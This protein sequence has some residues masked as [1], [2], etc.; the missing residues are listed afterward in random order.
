MRLKELSKTCDACPAQWEGRTVDNQFVYVRFRW[1]WLQIGFGK[2]IEDAINSS[3]AIW[4]SDDAYDGVMNTKDML[5]LA[6]LEIDA[7]LDSI[8][9]LLDIP[10]EC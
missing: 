3:K 10:Y 6:N 9:D 5:N 1:G 4:S 7:D 2:T 8:D